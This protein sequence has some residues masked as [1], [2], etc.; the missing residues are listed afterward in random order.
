M[1]SIGRKAPWQ[2]T[3]L[4]VA[5]LSGFLGCTTRTNATPGAAATKER[6]AKAQLM[7]EE[8]CKSAGEKIYRTADDV[9]GIFL[10]N[11]RPQH[12]NYDDQF[13]MNDPYGNDAD[14]DRYLES[15]IRGGNVAATPPD[16]V[17]PDHIGYLYVDAV[18]P[19]DGMRYRYGGHIEEPWQQDK[20]WL[21]GYTRFVL[22]KSRL[23]EPKPR[24]GLEFS[25]IST[26]QEREYWI[27]G[28]S[29]KVIDLETN[30]VVA[31][32]TGYMMD[33]QQG[34]R[35]QGR[36]PWLFAANNSCPAF[37]RDRH[38]H[39]AQFGQADRFIEKVLHPSKRGE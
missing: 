12:N 29:L 15:F 3:A 32:R 33:P 13:S 18:D 27:A 38:E 34:N 24:Y 2:C 39:L 21:K 6:L 8:R 1:K 4:L 35:D 28:S 26:R 36:S 37:S 20:H 11:R 31:E 19:Q 23:I 30:T 9:D 16:G 25:D 17:I 5:L 7:F 10:I 14:G 22:D